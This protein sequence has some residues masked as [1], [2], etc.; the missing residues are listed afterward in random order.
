MT[1]LR[2]AYQIVAGSGKV[3]AVATAEATD[4]VEK[5]QLYIITTN[6]DCYVRFSASAVAASDG[7]FD[8]FLPAGTSAVLR[9]TNATIRAIRA[10]ADG[11]LGIS[12]LEIV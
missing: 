10:T 3:I 2:D 9:A 4:T 6:T 7:N 11:V 1:I 5:H 12:K 8:I